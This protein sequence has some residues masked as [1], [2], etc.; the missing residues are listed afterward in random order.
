MTELTHRSM[1]SDE[2]GPYLDQMPDGCAQRMEFGGP[3]GQESLGYR[4]RAR[5]MT[6][7]L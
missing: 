1:T 4:T 6:K 2:L 5:Q 3:A 7:Q